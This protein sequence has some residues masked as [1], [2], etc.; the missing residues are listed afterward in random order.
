MLREYYKAYKPKTW[1]FEGQFPNTKYSEM[2][3]AKVLKTECPKSK[4]R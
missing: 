2:S 4:N 1:L 3:L